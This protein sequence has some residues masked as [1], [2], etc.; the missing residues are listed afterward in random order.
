M[1]AEFEGWC[2]KKSCWTASEVGDWSR[3]AIEICIGA[4]ILLG[5]KCGL[6]AAF[7]G[8][9][10]IQRGFAPFRHNLLVRSAFTC[11]N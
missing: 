10:C 3:Q 9:G 6:R 1:Q 7:Q 2:L 4:T 5:A 8:I 11:R